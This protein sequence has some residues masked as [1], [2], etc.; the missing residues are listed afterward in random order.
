MEKGEL[1]IVRFPS[2]KRRDAS[3]IRPAIIIADTKT[4]LTLLIPLTSNLEALE[5]L[6][7]TM[8]IKASNNNKLNKDSIVLIFQLQAI[9]KKRFISKIGH[10]EDSYMKEIDNLLKILLKLS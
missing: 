8:K 9:D 7:Y 3:G 5:K 2:R 4:D 1:W 10:L 6:P